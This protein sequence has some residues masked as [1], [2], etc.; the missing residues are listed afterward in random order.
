[1][2][3]TFDELTSVVRGRPKS[4]VA[5]AAAEDMDAITI[6]NECRDLADFVLIVV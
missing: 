2:I 6:A 4:T 1:M 5:V 3:R